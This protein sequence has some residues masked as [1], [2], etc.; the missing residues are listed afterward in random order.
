[1]GTAGRHCPEQENDDGRES[2]AP[3]TLRETVI[4]H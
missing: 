1:L 3:S 2:D 4:R